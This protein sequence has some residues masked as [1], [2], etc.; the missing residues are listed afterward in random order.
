MP[1]MNNGWVWEEQRK[2]LGGFRRM[3]KKGKREEAK[4]YAHMICG[5][6]KR[7]RFTVYA[8]IVCGW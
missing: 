7:W 1:C 5:V 8:Q 2:R 4:R 6:V 3:V